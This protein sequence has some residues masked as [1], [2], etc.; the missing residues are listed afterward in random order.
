M[1]QFVGDDDVWVFINNQLVIDLGGRHVQ[2][3]GSVALDTLE[4][5][6]GTTYNLDVFN[7][8]RHT[9]QSNF[10]IDTTLTL[11]NC[12]QVNGVIIY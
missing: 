2:L 12:G 9:T 10:R 8:E 1:N 6:P 5:I 4:L 11:A 3:S 7:A